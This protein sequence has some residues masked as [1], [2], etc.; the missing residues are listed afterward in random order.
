[1]IVSFLQ[2]GIGNTLFQ[3]AASIGTAEWYGQEWRIQGN[4]KYREYFNIPDDKYIDEYALPRYKE[5]HFHFSI[6]PNQSCELFG[7]F[8]SKKYWAHCEKQV[9]ELFKPSAK[10]QKWLDANDKKWYY[11]LPNDC[12]MHVRRGDYLNLKEYHYNLEEAYYREA[13]YQSNGN[14]TIFTDDRTKPLQG[15]EQFRHC[16]N[17]DDIQEFFLMIQFHVFI[18]A[19]SSFSWWASFLSERGKKIFAPPKNKWFGEKKKHYLVDNLYLPEW[20]IVNY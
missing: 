9:R 5:P 14:V 3:I 19:N 20:T 7:Y 2:G 4:W 12:A 11:E 1:M 16:P 6:I 10:M 15:F 18:I 13:I 8:Q 17:M